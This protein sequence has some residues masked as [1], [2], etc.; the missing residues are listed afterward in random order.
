MQE[1]KAEA[2]I[3]RT[4][5]IAGKHCK[6]VVHFGHD[7]LYLWNPLKEKDRRGPNI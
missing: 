5:I 6:K 4:T 2:N 3:M 7:N 1:E